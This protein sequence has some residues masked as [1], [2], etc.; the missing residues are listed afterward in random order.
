VK[1]KK[2]AG[3]DCAAPADQMIRLVLRTQLKALCKLRER[4]LDWSNPEGVHD[5]RVLSRR[6]RSAI[7]DF[8]SHL[9]KPGLP[10]R[11]LRA[12]AKSLGAVRDEDVA[13]AALVELQASA[14]DNAA[15]GIERLIEERRERQAKVRAVLMK[16]INTT[17][18]KD[19]R[20]EFQAQIRTLA[21]VGPKVAPA[22]DASVTVLTFRQVG[23]KA[24]SGRLKDFRD[25]VRSIYFPFEIQDLHELRILAKRLRYAVELFRYCWGKDLNETADEIAKLQTSLGEL[26]DC[27]VW[28]EYFGRQLKRA[29]R[30][31]SDD[32][33]SLRVCTGYNWLLRHFSKKRTEHYRDALVR[34]QQWQSDAFLDELKS[35]LK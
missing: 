18:V 22:P 6:M 33:E 12:I 10:I 15:E 8:Q 1:A 20:T 3:L 30:K 32:A 31:S 35:I 24:I 13:L 29:A 7:S 23:V 5:M 25:A 9:R 26:H 19:F 4:A 28:I 11:K 21:T 14:P 17:A 34:W 27:D 2:I 16:A